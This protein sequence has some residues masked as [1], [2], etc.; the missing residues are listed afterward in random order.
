MFVLGASSHFLFLQA[1]F[2]QV[3]ISLMDDFATS[4]IYLSLYYVQSAIVM[5]PD[6]VVV[7]V[8]S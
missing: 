5:H 3:H 2:S 4:Q 7:Q 8:L 6:P 1:L